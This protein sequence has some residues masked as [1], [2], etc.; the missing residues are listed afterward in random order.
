MFLVES[1][2]AAAVIRS[3]VFIEMVTAA[4]AQAI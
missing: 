4:P 2:A 3:L 1:C